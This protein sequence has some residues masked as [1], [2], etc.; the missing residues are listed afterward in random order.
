MGCSRLAAARVLL[1]CTGWCILR[2]AGVAAEDADGCTEGAEAR[3]PTCALAAQ[4]RFENETQNA[5]RLQPFLVLKQARSGSSWFASLVQKMCGMVLFEE[6]ITTSTSHQH[7][8]FQQKEYL[9]AL[10]QGFTDA[11]KITHFKGARQA[12]NATLPKFRD[13]FALGVTMNPLNN[14]N[15][16][17]VTP[18]GVEYQDS[19]YA[20]SSALDFKTIFKATGAKL[21]FYV[22]TN[23]VKVA[24]ARFRGQE[25]KF[26]CGGHPNIKVGPNIQPLNCTIESRTGVGPHELFSYVLTSLSRN[27]ATFD[28]GHGIPRPMEI[29]TYE[30]LQQDRVRELRRLKAVFGVPWTTNRLEGLCVNS[31]LVKRTGEDLREVLTN[32]KGIH[33]AWKREYL[34]TET[35]EQQVGAT[36]ILRMLRAATPK[37]FRDCLPKSR[38]R[39]LRMK[40]FEG[41]PLGREGGG[42][43]EMRQPRIP[44]RHA[45]EESERG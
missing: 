8:R 36:C 39:G 15:K 24:V 16:S 10:L 21:I 20:M 11:K 38:G 14:P 17:A 22:R 45:P 2:A 27:E 29:F 30:E 35:P 4:A 33:E 37:A 34:P 26:D 44:T 19:R 9:K 7:T 1:L 32:F 23:V 18:S 6:A 13:I 28:I 31:S 12:G 43:R 3:S 42:R 40:L 25:Y 5:T 41:A